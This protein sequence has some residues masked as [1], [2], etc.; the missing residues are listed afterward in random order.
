MTRESVPG[1]RSMNALSLCTGIGGMDI[2]AQA[3]GINIIAMCE[4][5]TFCRQI[6]KKHWPHVP[7][8]E[9]LAMLSGE[10][11]ERETGISAAAIDIIFAGFPC[12]R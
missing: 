11:I 10:V 1:K 5:D 8:F 12:Q 2:A 3:A 9:D 6:L 7:V 4:I